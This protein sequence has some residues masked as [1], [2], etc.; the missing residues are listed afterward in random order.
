M[1]NPLNMHTTGCYNALSLV[2]LHSCGT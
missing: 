1:M 2:T